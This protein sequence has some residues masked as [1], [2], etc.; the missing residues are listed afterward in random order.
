MIR[1]QNFEYTFRSLGIEP[2]VGDFQQFYQM[3]VSMGFFSFRQ[4]DG[5]PK[6]MVPPKGMTK[7]KTKFFY[8]KAVAIPA[9]LTFRNVTDAIIMET[10]SV[11]WLGT[12][13]WFLRLR[14]IGWKKLNNS[15]LWVLRMMLGR[16]SRKARPVVQEKSGEDAPLWRIFDPGFKGKV[17]VLAYADG[18]E[19]FNFTIRDN[20]RLPEREVMPAELPQGKGDLEALGYPDATGVPKKHVDK[21]GDKKLHKPKKPHELVFVP[22]L[23]PEVAGISRIRLCKYDNYVVVS[24]TLKGLCVLGG[25]AAMSGSS[26]GSKLAAE[27]KRKGDVAGAGGQKAPNLRW[28]HAGVNKEFTRSPS[29][30]VVTPLSARAEDTGKKA[31]GQTIVDTVDSSDNLTDPRDVNVGG[32]EKPKSPDATK[33]NSPIAKEKSFGLTAAGTRVE[34]QPSIQPGE[35]ELEFYYCSYAENQSVNYHR[36]PW[37]VMQ[38]DAISNDPSACRDILSGLGTPFEVLHARGLP[39]ENRIKQLSS[40]LVGSSIMANAIKED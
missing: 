40:M 7:W 19:G 35:T 24:D 20:F 39:R 23:V 38:G 17:E 34:N 37:A 33:P 11:P 26:A 8:I 3:T 27:R 31:A 29:I 18:E 5:I 28:T 6:L 30:E 32:G 14:I 21:H 22:P 10:I 4:R 1:V 16:M 12:V 13:D 36:P 15:Q 2:T 9:K 25:G